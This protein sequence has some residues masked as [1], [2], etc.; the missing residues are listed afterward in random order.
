MVKYNCTF[1]TSYFCVI[2]EEKYEEF[3]KHIV[4]WDDTN[5][6]NFWHKRGDCMES[7]SIKFD[8][9]EK[10][11]HAFGGY[12]Q[13]R[14]YVEDIEHYD[15]KLMDPSPDYDL[16]LQKLSEIVAPGSACIIT[17]VGNN[18]LRFIGATADIVTHKNHRTLKLQDIVKDNLLEKERIPYNDGDMWF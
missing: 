3:K 10:I 1:R 14:G 13:I 5:G 17:E 15:S 9:N 2:D 8:T 7:D 16:F 6:I 12:T 18:A 4:V 11:R